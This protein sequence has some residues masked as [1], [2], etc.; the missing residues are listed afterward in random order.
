MQFVVCYELFCTSCSLSFF[1][2]LPSSF[3]LS[4]LIDLSSSIILSTTV[5]TAPVINSKTNLMSI[6]LL[7]FPVTLLQLYVFK[8]RNQQSP[9]WSTLTYVYEYQKG[10][11]GSLLITKLNVKSVCNLDRAHTPSL[12][13]MTLTINIF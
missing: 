8:I 4:F 13:K 2:I 3:V 6:I 10:S 11:L 7:S 5:G 12:R 9:P 1:Y